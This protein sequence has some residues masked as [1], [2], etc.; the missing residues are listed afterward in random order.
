M[1]TLLVFSGVCLLLAMVP[2]PGA[3][4][5]LRQA[6]HEGRR[7]AFLTL[8]GN[9]T[10]LVLWGFAAAG[11]LTVLI[12]AS[13]VAYDVMRFAGAGVLLVLGFQAIAGARRRAPQAMPEA[14]PAAARPGG[15]RPYSVGLI[16]NLTNPKA[17]VL[18]LSFLP[19]FVHPGRPALP[20][21]MSLA[22][23]WALVDAAW[24]TL[25]IWFIGKART[26]F[27]RATIWRRLTR[28]SGAV[29]IGLGLRLALE[30]Q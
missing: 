18:A 4:V 12:T 13:R 2:G 19:Q 20:A 16:A 3:M 8:L 9:E 10:A 23:L 30:S 17:A 27:T 25:V 21:L 11:G 22:V 6:V 5:I 28:L 24:F 26:Y 14:L 29:L 15:W 7:P 1:R